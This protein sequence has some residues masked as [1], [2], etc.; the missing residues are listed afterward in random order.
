M[1]ALN[2][3][4][5]IP[6]NIDTLEE[7]L[8]WCLLTAHNLYGGQVFQELQGALLEREIDTSIVKV[9]DGTTRLLF[10][11]AL[12]VDDEYAN[13]TLKLWFLAQEWGNTAIPAAFKVNA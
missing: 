6:S 5:D 4:T 12:K 10:R 13:S 1:A 2:L 8:A 7:L 9:A 3:A 11:G